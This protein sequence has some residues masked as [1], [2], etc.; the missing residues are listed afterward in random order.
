MSVPYT[1]LASALKP[2]SSARV[3]DSVTARMPAAT[4]CSG[5][6]VPPSVTS[7][8]SLRTRRRLSRKAENAK[9][10][11][12]A[13]KANALEPSSSISAPTAGPAMIAR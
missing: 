5:P 11:A 6:A 9:L 4:C 3:D 13:P 1:K 8:G 10:S 2:T 7:V 12:L